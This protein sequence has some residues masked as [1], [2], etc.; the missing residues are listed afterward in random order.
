MTAEMLEAERKWL[1][2]FK[3]KKVTPKPAVHIPAN[4]KAIELAWTAQ[5]ILKRFVDLPVEA[6]AGKSAGDSANPYHYTVPAI[7]HP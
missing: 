4:V 7:T 1:P 6:V 5:A 2:Q 3:G